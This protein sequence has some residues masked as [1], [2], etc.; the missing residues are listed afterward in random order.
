[1]SGFGAGRR[2]VLNLILQRIGLGLVTLLVVSA[3][4]F[5]ITEVLPG[6]VAT[7][8]LGQQATLETLA[9]LRRQLGLEQPA[10]L[11]YF[12]W[13]AGIVQG[14]LGISLASNREIAP[15]LANRLGLTLFLASTVAI[16]AIPLAIG[17]GLICAI[18]RGSLFDRG[19]SIATLTMISV[20]EFFIAYMLIFF[21]AV[22]LGY[23]PS[24]SMIRP[25]MNFV[26]MLYTITLPA[27]TLLMIVLAYMMRMTRIAVL[28]IMTQ[29]YIEMA[30][31]KGLQTWRVVVFHALPNALPPIINVIALNLA[32]LIVGVIVVEVVFVYPGVGQYMVDAVA[33]RDIPVVQACAL[34]FCVTY[35]GL[36]LIADVCALISNPRLRHP[37]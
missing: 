22:Q 24:L 7:A 33:K 31:L 18:Y 9:V 6:D 14:D 5:A 19:V 12:Q 27:T 16:I 21:F 34:I 29:P 26:D 32:F 13:L 35:V 30:E 28:N 2:V 4:I 25:G 15:Q 23:F 8:I 20:P 37:R 36:N 11:R 17:L 3:M 1:M 10:V